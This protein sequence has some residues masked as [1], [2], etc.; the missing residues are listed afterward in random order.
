M[1]YLWGYFFSQD[2]QRRKIGL[3]NVS[4]QLTV[5][6]YDP[7]Y[8]ALQGL[9]GS[10]IFKS[11]GIEGIIVFYNGSFYNA[12]D[13]CSPI[14]PEERFPLVLD[15][16]GLLLLDTRNGAKYELMGMG[17]PSSGSAKGKLKMYDVMKRGDV[18][19][20]RN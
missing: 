19:H 18:L 2:A 6:L 10:A 5:N 17:L 11:H 16:T 20:I 12:F 3:P 1:V 7:Q 15:D 9:G 8:R 14:D 4:V 13:L